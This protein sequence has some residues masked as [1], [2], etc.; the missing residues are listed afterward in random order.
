[1]SGVQVDTVGNGAAF[2]GSNSNSMV[3]V[4]GCPVPC[5][6]GWAEYPAGCRVASRWHRNGTTCHW[7]LP[8][9]SSAHCPL[10]RTRISPSLQQ[11]GRPAN[12]CLS[13]RMLAHV[14]GEGGKG[15]CPQVL[16][17][18]PPKCCGEAVVGEV[19]GQGGGG[20]GATR[21]YGKSKMGECLVN[22]C[23]AKNEL[24]GTMCVTLHTFMGE[25][26]A[27]ENVEVHHAYR[28][29]QHIRQCARPGQAM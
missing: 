5:G 13:F 7:S 25:A 21:N 28:E 18:C 14:C 3:A 27:R 6:C 12:S 15:G 2:G 10:R 29:G 9:F 17:G 20:Q 16:G 4:V 26:P 24:D 19:G 11:S 22:N 1:M 8:V 23:S